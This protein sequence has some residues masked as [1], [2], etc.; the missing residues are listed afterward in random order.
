MTAFRLFFLRLFGASIGVGSDIRSSAQ[1]WYPPNLRV[2]NHSTIGPGVLIYNMAPVIIGDNVI[3]SQRAFLCGGTHSTSEPTFPLISREINID[4]HSW[5][6]AEAFVAP[7]VRVEEGAVLG[8]RGV[9]FKNLNA[10]TIY[11]GNPAVVLRCR[12]TEKF[13]HLSSIAKQKADDPDSA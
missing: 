12:P 7:G 1:I 6:A 11:Y 8:A 13:T 3:I 2:G 4:S 9:A 10:W 5:I